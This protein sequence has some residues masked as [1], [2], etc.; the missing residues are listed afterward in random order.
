MARIAPS[1]KTTVIPST[2]GRVLPYLNVAGPAA[3]VAMVP[4]TKAPSNVGTGG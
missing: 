3:L 1:A 2:H 4:P